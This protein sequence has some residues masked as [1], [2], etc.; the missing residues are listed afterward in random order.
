MSVK[1]IV[2]RPQL[3]E[4][5]T[6]RLQ[7]MGAHFPIDEERREHENSTRRHAALL[8]HKNPYY[9]NPLTGTSDEPPNHFTHEK[10]SRLMAKH[11]ALRAVKKGGFVSPSAHGSGARPWREDAHYKKAHSKLHKLRKHWHS[12]ALGESALQKMIHLHRKIKRM[13]KGGML[14]DATPVGAGA[15]GEAFKKIGNTA[16]DAAPAVAGAAFGPVGSAVARLAG[17]AIRWISGKIAARH[18]RRKEGK[19]IKFIALPKKNQRM[20]D[21]KL[22]HAALESAK[23]SVPHMFRKEEGRAVKEETRALVKHLKRNVLGDTLHTKGRSIAGKG[24]VS[25]ADVARPVLV[26]IAANRMREELGENEGASVKDLESKDLLKYLL[27][28]LEEE[29][30]MD[31]PCETILVKGE[32]LR[33]LFGKLKGLVKRFGPKLAGFARSHILPGLADLA[34]K[35]AADHGFSKED[36]KTVVDFAKKHADKFLE[37]VEKGSDRRDEKGSDRRDEK[38]GLA[39]AKAAAREEHEREGPPSAGETVPTAAS[40]P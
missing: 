12:G 21:V 37:G 20:T 3:N 33:D 11:H 15:V 32:G 26:G 18:Q 34:S 30:G 6:E 10:V 31:K 7:S 5:Q 2:D 22:W 38:K 40:T 9:V 8:A 16:L 39:P 36:T 17:S 14:V 13:K 19:G 28:H 27:E 24:Y 35:V 23:H 25:V 29:E 4:V 1:D